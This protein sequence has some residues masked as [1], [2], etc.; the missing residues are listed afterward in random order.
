VWHAHRG[1]LADARRIAAILAARADSSGQSRDSLFARI[2]AAHV[3]L[4]GGDTTQARDRL[5]ALL[6]RADPDELAWSLWSPLGLER[7]LLARILLAQRDFEGALRVASVFDSAQP[8]A[9]VRDLPAS[10]QLRLR[11]AQA[12][13]RQDLVT[14]YRARLALFVGRDVNLSRI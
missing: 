3:A 13:G 4:G 10:L 1:P 6:P 8:I 7:L 11:A 2:V 5:E 14:H 9:Y 12:L